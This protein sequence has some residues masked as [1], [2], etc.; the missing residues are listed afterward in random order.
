MDNIWT[1]YKEPKIKLFKKRAIK[2]SFGYFIPS[3][4]A[5]VSSVVVCD[6]LLPGKQVPVPGLEPESVTLVGG[7]VTNELT[8]V[9]MCVAA[10][11]PFKLRRHTI[12]VTVHSFAQKL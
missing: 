9:V 1:I 6:I 8:E 4:G 5:K 12:Y 7:H 11:L 10:W 2:K 3:H